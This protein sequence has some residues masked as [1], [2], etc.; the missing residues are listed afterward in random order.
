MRNKKIMS[1][2]LPPKLPELVPQQLR[3]LHLLLLPL[4]HQVPAPAQLATIE[5]QMFLLLIILNIYSWYFFIITIL[6]HEA[7][8]YTT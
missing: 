3:L 4:P 1:Y 6:P 7:S 5:L 8:S 2:L